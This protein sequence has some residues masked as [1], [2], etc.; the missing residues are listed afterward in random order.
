MSFIFEYMYGESKETNPIQYRPRKGQRFISSSYALKDWKPP[1]DRMC[2]S[3][4]K[5]RR[6]KFN[7]KKLLVQFNDST[8]PCAEYTD[9]TFF[10]NFNH[11]Q[12]VDIFVYTSNGLICIPSNGYISAGH[13]NGTKVLGTIM[14]PVFQEQ[15]TKEF[16][17]L[18][19]KDSDGNFVCA[20][21]LI[22][23]AT[24]YGFDG[25]FV[26]IEELL[27]ETVEWNVVQGFCKYLLDGLRTKNEHAE[28][29]WYDSNY[30][31][32]SQSYENKL[33]ANNKVMFQDESN[34]SSGFFINYS[35]DKECIVESC[36]TAEKI[37]RNIGD[38]YAGLYLDDVHS[39]SIISR[40]N[41]CSIFSKDISSGL[42]GLG[43]IANNA[44]TRR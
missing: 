32:S 7:K 13:L 29:I 36:K 5:L 17:T 21:K 40:L 27:P 3:K 42:W 20:D 22:E 24:Y 33:D 37:K 26:N 18:F 39:G 8:S 41:E 1:D 4:V 2:V 12:F 30:I 25:W 14:A 38:V 23:I 28:I 19:E 44:A 31:F 11:W 9:K 34:I 35:W 16:I 43:N 10:F 6:H 15:Y